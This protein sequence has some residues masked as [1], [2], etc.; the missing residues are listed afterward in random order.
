MLLYIYIF[1]K[2]SERAKGFGEIECFE[3]CERFIAPLLLYYNGLNSIL[4]NIFNPLFFWIFP[5]K[6]N[7]SFFLSLLIRSLLTMLYMICN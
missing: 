1:G 6:F 3:I 7:V 2:V 5:P 4:P